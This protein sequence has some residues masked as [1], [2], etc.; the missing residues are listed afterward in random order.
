MEEKKTVAL[1]LTGCKSLWELH[2]RMQK[3]FDFPDWYGKNWSAFEDM[4]K[5]ECSAEKI[6][7]SGEHTLPKE[8]QRSIKTMHEI[9]QSA[10]E[11]SEQFGWNFEYCIIS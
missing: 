4:I 7:I 1:D 11:E 2:Q 3:A 9:L 6:E 5:N 8:L 10:K